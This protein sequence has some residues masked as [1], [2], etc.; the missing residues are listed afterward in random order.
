M[1]HSAVAR[2][3]YHEFAAQLPIVDYHNH[4]DPRAIANDR[5]YADIGELWV[6]ADPYKHR[7]MRINGIPERLI[8]GDAASREKFDAW[9][10]TCPMTLGNPLYH[11]SALELKRVFDIDEPLTAHTANAVWAMCN[12]QLARAEFSACGLLRRWGVEVL[13]TSDD[14]L[15]DVSVHRRATERA[16]HFQVLP[17]LRGDSMLAVGSPSYGNWLKRLGESEKIDSLDAL[18][19][20]IDRRLDAFDASGCCVADHSLDEEFYFA[21]PERAG[22]ERCFDLL[23]AGETLTAAET[24]A[25][26]SYL[27]YQLGRRYAIRG[28]A[29]LLHIGAER[30]TSSRLRRLAGPAGGY[31]TIGHTCDVQSLCRL[32]DTLE[33]DDA[34]PRTMLFTLNPA[35]NATL[36]TLTGSY[37]EEGRW[38]K[39]Q[40]GPAWWYN[41]HKMG[42]ESHLDHLASY[43]LL[44]RFVG[45]TTDSRSIL[46]FSRHEYFRR[47]LCDYM[48]SLATRGEVPMDM[49][50]LGSVVE[51]IACRNAREWI[52]GKQE[53]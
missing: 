50:L 43:G 39:I 1:L 45:M 12:E 29:M 15:D 51:G 13:C 28:W 25:L 23:L 14:L 19:A 16:G 21:A 40:Y 52:F 11:W 24:I 36:A 31:A 33:S 26:R 22:A 17:S 32:L 41:D 48:G 38:G 20:A 42:I 30:F 5:R 34:L 27:L 7:A 46:S 9:A 8:S 37:A 3:L 18:L 10:A 35:D 2:T 53:K 6:V 44:A 47:I 49:E 4:L